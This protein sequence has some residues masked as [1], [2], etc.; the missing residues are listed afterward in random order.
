MDRLGIFNTSDA[1]P[2]EFYKDD[3]DDLETC[4][5]CDEDEEEGYTCNCCEQDDQDLLS[6]IHYKTGEHETICENC[7]AEWESEEEDFRDNYGITLIKKLDN[8]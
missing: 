2:P 5:N 4:D 7:L 1:N 6:V 3:E 8:D